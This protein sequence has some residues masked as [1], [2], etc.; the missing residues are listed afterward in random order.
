MVRKPKGVDGYKGEHVD[1]VRYM[2]YLWHHDRKHIIHAKHFTV[3]F[4][5][6]RVPRRFHAN[7][8]VEGR[9]AFCGKRPEIALWDSRTLSR[10]LSFRSLARDLASA[11]IANDSPNLLYGTGI[12]RGCPVWKPLPVGRFLSE[13]RVVWNVVYIPR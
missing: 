6:L 13:G 12:E 5:L 9:Y 1:R 4:G 3:S 7:P 11:R 10:A 2:G 8:H